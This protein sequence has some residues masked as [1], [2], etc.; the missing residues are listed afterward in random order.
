VVANLG[1]DELNKKTVW[2]N[3]TNFLNGLADLV[4]VIPMTAKEVI[5]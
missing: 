1:Y 4:L 2:W 3:F 5:N